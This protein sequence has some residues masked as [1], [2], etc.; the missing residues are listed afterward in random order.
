LGGLKYRRLPLDDVAAELIFNNVQKAAP[1]AAFGAHKIQSA[2]PA[3]AALGGSAIS[4]R[5]YRS[6]G[7]SA[8]TDNRV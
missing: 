2:L 3:D 4:T 8:F 5:M 6:T 7:L 1:P